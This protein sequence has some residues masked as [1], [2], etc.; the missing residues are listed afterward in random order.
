MS[1]HISHALC[2]YYRGILASN[3]SLERSVPTVPL[4]GCALG[5]STNGFRAAAQ[6]NR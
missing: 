2:V 5:T 4:L 1:V 3:R 6:F